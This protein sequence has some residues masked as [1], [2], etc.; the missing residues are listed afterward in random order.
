MNI[1]TTTVLASALLS[2]WPSPS[3]SATRLDSVRFRYGSL[4]RSAGT[5]IFQITPQTANLASRAMFNS[6][7]KLLS[8]CEPSQ[9][10]HDDTNNLHN[11]HTLTLQD[12]SPELSHP[13]LF[14]PICSKNSPNDFF[15]IH[16]IIRASVPFKIWNLVIV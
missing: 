8:A 1:P 5:S 15:Q 13:Q 11:T 3:K 9:T 12:F 16:T 10:S 4:L 2:D 7:G 14:P 6:H